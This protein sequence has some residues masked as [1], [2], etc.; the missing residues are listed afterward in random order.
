MSE[1]FSPRETRCH[2]GCGQDVDPRLLPALEEL[3]YRNGDLPLVVVSGRRCV[4]WNGIVHGAKKSLHVAG[5]AADIR[6]PTRDRFEI[7]FFV[8]IA[9]GVGFTG[10]GLYRDFVHLDLRH[11]LELPPATWDLRK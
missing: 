4:R 9:R 8:K 3:R 11:L 10:V 6:W 7:E 1:H 5:L 2:C